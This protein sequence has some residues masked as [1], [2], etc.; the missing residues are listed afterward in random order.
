MAIEVRGRVMEK[1]SGRGLGGVLV[2]NGEQIVQTDEEGRYA[3]AVEPE[4]PV[5]ICDRSGCA[6]VR[7]FSG[8][9]S[10]H[11][12]SIRLHGTGW[13]RKM[14]WILGLSLHLSGLHGSL[15]L[16]RLLIHTL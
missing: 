8:W 3:L 6:P 14:G 12:G 5:R 1:P 16:C 4:A 11:R 2:S 13:A 9:F 15:R 10:R 7:I